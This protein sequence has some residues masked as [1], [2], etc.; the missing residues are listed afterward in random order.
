MLDRI[1]R[2]LLLAY[3]AL[4]VYFGL[5][6]EARPAA[7]P[8]TNSAQQAIVILRSNGHGTKDAPDRAA[9]HAAATQTRG[10]K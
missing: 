8:L 4:L 10:T 3:A 5:A 1:V 9:H 2:A 6:Q 7:V